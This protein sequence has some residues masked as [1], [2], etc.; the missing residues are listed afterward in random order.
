MK[1]PPSFLFFALIALC[2]IAMMLSACTVNV[3]L[4]QDGCYGRIYGGYA[5]PVPVSEKIPSEL[6]VKN[7]N[8]L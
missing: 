3:P 6:E 5:P 4:G 8:P 1:L 2:C 7:L